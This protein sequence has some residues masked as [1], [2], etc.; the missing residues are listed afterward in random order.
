[1]QEDATEKQIEML[2]SFGIEEKYIICKGQACYLLDYFFQRRKEGLCSYKQ[3][4]MLSRYKI[5]NLDL[6]DGDIAKEA[7]NFLSKNKWKPTKEFWDLLK[8]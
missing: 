8:E 7:M 4:K 3:A 1:M 5:N 2:K 6:L